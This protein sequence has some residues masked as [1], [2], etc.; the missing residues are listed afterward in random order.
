[1]TVPCWRQLEL[2]CE[3]RNGFLATT[4]D[5][6]FSFLLRLSD[7]GHALLSN[8]PI[9]TLRRWGRHKGTDAYR[10]I[11]NVIL[12]GLIK[13]SETDYEMMARYYSAIGNGQHV[14]KALV[15]QMR[16]GELIHHILQALRRSAAREGRGIECGP[17][18]AHHRSEAF[19]CLYGRSVRRAQERVR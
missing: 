13:Y 11:Q 10:H 1:M 16:S 18:N 7:V 4:K 6:A 17:C 12:A 19:R 8:H 14:P 5:K 9:W 2:G 3:R 15:K